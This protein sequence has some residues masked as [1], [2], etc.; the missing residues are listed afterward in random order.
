MRIK[1]STVKLFLLTDF[2]CFQFIGTFFTTPFSSPSMWLHLLSDSRARNKKNNEQNLTYFSK[3]FAITGQY[4]LVWIFIKIIFSLDRRF[5]YVYIN[6]IVIL[7]TVKWFLIPKNEAILL[8]FGKM[9]LMSWIKVFT[10]QTVEL[11]DQSHILLF[12]YIL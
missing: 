7:P 6:F 8:F 12:E 2:R 11:T 9:Y 3:R 10:G 1:G 4:W 5:T